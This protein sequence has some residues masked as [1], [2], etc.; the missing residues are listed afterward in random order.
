MTDPDTDEAIYDPLFLYQ[1]FQQAVAEWM[2]EHSGRFVIPGCEY[3]P[4]GVNSRKQAKE[5]YSEQAAA[6][7]IA[8]W[9]DRYYR[10]ATAE[11]TSTNDA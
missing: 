9:E 4:D 5:H 7:I 2:A 11:R 10:A 8:A 1:T 3:W 6:E